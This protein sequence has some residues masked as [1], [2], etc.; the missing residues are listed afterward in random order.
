MMRL[1]QTPTP[2]NTA[3]PS[4]TPTNTPSNT[5]TGTACPG[6]TPT[7]TPTNTPTPSV[8]PGLPE[9]PTPT[10]TATNTP[11]PTSTPGLCICETYDV[12]N[13]SL[14]IIEVSWIDCDGN[15]QTQF[16]DTN[17]ALRICACQG[18][19]I[20]EGGEI[21][22][23]GACIPESPTPTPTPT[24]TPGLCICET[25]DVLNNNEFSIEV[26]WVD[27]NGL[28]RIQILSGPS[29]LRIC[30]C[31]GSV[32]A[33]GGEITD[34]GACVAC[35]CISYTILNNSP[36]EIMN[37]DWLNCDGRTA[38]STIIQPNTGLSICACNGTVTTLGG[39]PEIIDMGPCEG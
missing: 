11:T 12:L 13:M 39:T 20:A 25:Y 5:P 16:I 17:T 36:V 29:A 27:C 23:I 9:T 10:P 37:V 21:T 35:E 4:N 14:F 3:T 1:T 32:V 19:V 30:A 2:S 26:T 33:E 15:S 38:E 24:S 31:Q 18:S 6:L 7:R 22:D 34:I 28:S 8:T